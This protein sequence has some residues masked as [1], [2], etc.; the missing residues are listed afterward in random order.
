MK[1][2]N[3]RSVAN[4][5]IKSEASSLNVIANKLDVNFDK[6]CDVIMDCKGKVITIGLGKSGYIAA[7][8]AATFSSTGTPS[9]FLHAAEAPGSEADGERRYG[10]V[11]PA[12][13]GPVRA[14]L[15]APVSVR[16]RGRRA[17]L[18]VRDPQARDGRCPTR[19]EDRWRP[20]E[21]T[22]TIRKS[23]TFLFVLRLHKS[24]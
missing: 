15:E 12:G 20:L 1:K 10:L 11:L 17:D 7:K 2:I 3:K 6:A 8:S 13:D 16:V 4:K 14:R 21:S 19:A 9:I 18:R 5:V 24:K 22:G 23:K